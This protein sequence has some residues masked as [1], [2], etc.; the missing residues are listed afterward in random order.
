MAG[1]QVALAL[2]SGGARGYAH[3]G[4][5][6]VL[7]ERGFDIVAVAGS[8][9]GA[10]VGGLYAADVLDDYTTWATSLSQLDIWRLLDPSLSAAGAFKA[11]KA[12]GKVRDLLDGV[13]IED[14]RIPFTAVATDL[15]AGREVWF[16]HGPADRAIRASIA[17]P[18]VIT[19]VMHNGRLLA[20]GGLLNPVPLAP[21]SSVHADATIAVYLGG[22]RKGAASTPGGAPEHESAEQ[23][24]VDEW[25]ERFRR[26]ASGW[27]ESDAIKAVTSRVERLLERGRTDDEIDE[28]E[29]VEE[30]LPAGLSKGDVLTLSIEVMQAMLTRYRLASYPPDVLVTI[31]R[32]ACRALDF[33]RAAELIEVGRG[34]AE[35]ALDRAG[36]TSTG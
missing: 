8:S 10:M 34:A 14:M 36:L 11:E 1:R 16:Q 15:L 33:H 4:V 23:R 35:E 6:Q 31:P 18:T 19:P 29:E 22:E 32:D 25:S 7:D 5:L 2:G 12:F 20:D 21:L 30:S 9:M 3:I 13:L 27:L 17:I 28:V 24:P 26:V